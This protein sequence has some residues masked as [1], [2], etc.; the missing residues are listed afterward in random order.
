MSKRSGQPTPRIGHQDYDV[1]TQVGYLLRRAYQRHTALFQEKIPDSQL[2][3][4]QFVT[5]CAVRDLGECSLNDIVKRTAIDQATIRGVVDRLVSRELVT[6][7]SHQ[8]D[9]R[10]RVVS[11]TSTG[12]LLLQEMVPHARHVTERTFGTFNPGE[13]EALLFLLKKMCTAP[14]DR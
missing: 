4:G 7:T 8:Q 9:A 11:L 3:A 1:T 10:K 2:T 13:R 12:V 6:T 5:L 14:G